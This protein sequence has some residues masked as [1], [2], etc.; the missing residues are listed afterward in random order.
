MPATHSVP[1]TQ[2]PDVLDEFRSVPPP[3]PEPTHGERARTLLAATTTGALSTMAVDHPGHPFGSVVSYAVEDDGSVLL[4]LSDLAEH[5]RNLAVRPEA[6]LLATEPGEADDPLALGRVTLVGT[7]TAVD[8]GRE[9]GVRDRYLA[10]H[11]GAYYADFDDF[12]FY[13]FAVVAVRYV[14]GF[15]HMSW[16]DPAQY[17]A[18]EPDPLHPHARAILGHMNG[19]HADALVAYARTFGE[20]PG[21]TAATMLRVDRY[22]FDV[23]AETPAGRR[24]FRIPF[25]GRT[26]TTDGVRQETI[27]L[28][29]EARA[30]LAT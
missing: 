3:S 30:R 19:D 12:R 18:S 25:A 7:I 13:R 22:G 28:L 20:L 24:T 4:C 26:D 14:G 29:T 23:L 1:R 5:S 17:A 21:T 2:L 10:A 27:R 15:G 9:P 8:T 6:S 11:P 16:V